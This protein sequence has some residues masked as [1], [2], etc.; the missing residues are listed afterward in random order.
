[1]FLTT[2]TCTCA[3]I[4]IHTYTHNAKCSFKQFCVVASFSALEASSKLGGEGLDP[5]YSMLD[6]GRDGEFFAELEDYFYYAQ[7]MRCVVLPMHSVLD[8]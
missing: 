3:H 6:G 2:G 5:F 7:I 8:S 1:M 4:T